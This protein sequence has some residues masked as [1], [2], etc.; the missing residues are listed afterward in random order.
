M[1]TTTDKDFKRFVARC[2]FWRKRFGLINWKVS[3]EHKEMSGRDGVANI[4]ADGS[5]ML[6]IIRFNKSREQRAN[7]KAIDYTA[8][9]EVLHLLLARYAEVAES[10]YASKDE[11]F[12]AEEEVVV[13]MSCL[14]TD[15]GMSLSQIKK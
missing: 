8:C 5:S 12:A 15:S 11:L 7:N 1:Y 4:S 10:R 14:F 3:Y 2:E 9:H 13:T 6:A